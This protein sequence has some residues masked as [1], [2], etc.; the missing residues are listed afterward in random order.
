MRTQAVSCAALLSVAIAASIPSNAQPPGPAAP[1]PAQPAGED[2]RQTQRAIAQAKFQ[3]ALGAAREAHRL[4]PIAVEKSVI[5]EETKAN[6]QNAA[7]ENALAD[8]K[9][10][11]SRARKAFNEA[12][13][14]AATSFAAAK[15]AVQELRRLGP[16]PTGASPV[17]GLQFAADLDAIGDCLKVLEQKLWKRINS[18]LTRRNRGYLWRD[19][20]TYAASL[21]GSWAPAEASG[22][23]PDD[24]TIPCTGTRV[25]MRVAPE[26]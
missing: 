1:P 15:R 13:G 7:C 20:Q 25:P 14:K 5:Y 21:P 9:T 2:P 22:L 11:S 24:V 26:K 8:A 3:E 18:A 10:E 23:V 16:D 12:R 17:D 6:R 4:M 19:T